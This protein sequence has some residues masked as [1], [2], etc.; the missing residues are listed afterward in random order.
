VSGGA[1]IGVCVGDRDFH[2]VA[3]KQFG[4]QQGRVG[5][6]DEAIG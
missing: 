1:S 2:S 6:M 5:G 3:P 4:L